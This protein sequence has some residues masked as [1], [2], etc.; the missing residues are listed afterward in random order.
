MTE[1]DAIAEGIDMAEGESA[2]AA[3]AKLWEEIHGAGAWA[4]NPVVWVLEFK[5]VG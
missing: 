2:V 5:V 3:Y 1:V 4:K